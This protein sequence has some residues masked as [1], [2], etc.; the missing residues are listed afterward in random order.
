MFARCSCFPSSSQSSPSSRP[1]PPPK[2]AS[3]AQ[4]P[5]ARRPLSAHREPG[6]PHA[7]HGHAVG[8]PSTS[9]G[10]HSPGQAL[11]L[12]GVFLTGTG[13]HLRNGTLGQLIHEPLS[14]DGVGGHTVT[15]ITI[16]GPVDFAGRR[17]RVTPIP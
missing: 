15:D 9:A 16:Q 7:R 11:V 8:P 1:M 14:L 17:P 6:L 5:G 2:A 13:A 4:H 12:A 3:V 10:L